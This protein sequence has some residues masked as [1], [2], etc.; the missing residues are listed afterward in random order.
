M[1]HEPSLRPLLLCG[2][3]PVPSSY[4]VRTI[5]GHPTSFSEDGT[6]MV[7]AWYEEDR[8]E[9]ERERE[10]RAVGKAT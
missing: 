5:F 2:E 8:E 4:H 9:R 1:I 7:Q 3:S 10:R 6:N